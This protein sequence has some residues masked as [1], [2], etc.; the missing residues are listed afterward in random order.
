MNKTLWLSLITAGCLYGAAGETQ[1]VLGDVAKLRA[2][3]EECRQNQAQ[4]DNEKIRG[5]Q[6]RIARLEERIREEEAKLASHAKRLR[7]TEQELSRKK[8]VVQSL[9]KTLTSRDAQYRAAIE[10]NERLAKEANAI[11]VGKIERENLTKALAG[12]KA[13]VSRLEA[14]LKKGKGESKDKALENAR[15]QIERLRRELSEAKAAKAV[16]PPASGDALRVQALQRELD[17]AHLAITQLQNAAP[18]ERIV[19]KVVEPTEKLSA[20]QRELDAARAEIANLKKGVAK[21]AAPREKIVEKVVYRD[22]PVEKIVTKTVEP[23]EKI[24]ALQSELASARATIEKLK[25][26]PSQHV[27]EKVVYKE[28]PV[29]KVVEKVVYRDRPVVQEKLVEKVVYRDRPV[30]KIVTKTIEPTDKLKALETRLADARGEISRLKSE[31]AALR[32]KPLTVASAPV[33]E[34]RLV[35]PSPAEP[36][37]RVQ[38]APGASA[39]KGGASAYRMASD[40]PI[41]NAP[42]GAI[43][44]TWEARRSFTAGEPSGGW[45]RITGYFVNRVWQPARE[46]ERLWVRESDVMRR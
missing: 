40:A 32:N 28:K 20:I 35:Q 42:G 19:T 8:G 27:V 6:K 36:A 4:N 26:T 33:R 38:T 29:E 3:Y 12:A 11:K 39:K 30:E 46:D 15:S 16:P 41:Y 23:T 43:V 18:K 22:R 5:Y 31:L 45:V 2:K 17:K 24:R 21:P 7:E 37:K 1:S 34:K 25:K 9:E 44:D 13:E 14:E 10:R